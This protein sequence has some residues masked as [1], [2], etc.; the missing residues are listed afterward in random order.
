MEELPP[1][2][3][4]RLQSDGNTGSLG[5]MP[6]LG[7][8]TGLYTFQAELYLAENSVHSTEQRQFMVAPEST[9]KVVSWQI[10][11]VVIGVMLIAS[12]VTVAFVLYRRR[13]MF[14]DYV[15]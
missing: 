1:L 4:S 12:A 14:R 2:S 6:S 10:L 11:G 5:Y 9:T 13:D 7:W 3:L 15:E 8:R